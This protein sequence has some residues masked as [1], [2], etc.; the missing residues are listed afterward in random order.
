MTGPFEKPLMVWTAEGTVWLT[1]Q[2]RAEG[3]VVSEAL[4]GGSQNSG[5]PQV[6]EI[7]VG[8]GPLRQRVTF[9]PGLGAY[10]QGYGSWDQGA[11]FT[12]P[13]SEEAIAHFI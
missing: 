9:Q 5:H 6:R 11:Q 1:P 12:I 8:E 7:P 13:A 3:H 4:H 10:I 2:T